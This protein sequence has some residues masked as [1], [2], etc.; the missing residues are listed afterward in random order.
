[1]SIQLNQALHWLRQRL[2][3][4][5]VLL[6]LLAVILIFAVPPLYRWTL[7]T[8]VF[9]YYGLPIKLPVSPYGHDVKLRLGNMEGVPLAI[10]SNLLE[11]AVEY[12]DKSAWE[13][14][15]KGYYES[16]TAADPIRNFALYLHW[17]DLAG[18]SAAN[19]ESFWASKKTAGATDW[20]AISVT[21]E[22]PGSSKRPN[23]QKRG[24]EW[25]VKQHMN[26]LSEEWMTKHPTTVLDLVT[27]EKHVIRDAHYELRERDPVTGLQSAIPVGRDTERYF[28]SN[29]A[30][31]W[32]GDM[33]KKLD[34]VIA[35][36]RGKL[37]N[38][39]PNAV[40]KC[41]HRYLLPELGA[42]VTLYYT[43]NWLPHWQELQ[44]KT[45]DF[46]L[47]LRTQPVPSA[48]AQ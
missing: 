10:P 28:S 17:P 8:F 27:E 40:L 36:P 5:W 26:Y 1:M 7:R 9:P 16:K 47:A 39:N 3:R 45:R 24:L 6:A 25:V 46:V 38:S 18:R 20:I 14:K 22:H 31:Y 48:H 19:E 32:K 29:T 23:A 30:L 35:C 11:F 13:P 15:G 33:N 34:F 2:A 41:E 12:M 4:R 42:D 21:N 37:R 43:P 44:S